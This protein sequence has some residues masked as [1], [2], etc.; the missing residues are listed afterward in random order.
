[1]LFSIFLQY[2]ILSIS[3]GNCQRDCNKVKLMPKI[4][5]NIL[6][7]SLDSPMYREFLLIRHNLLSKNMADQLDIYWYVP[8]LYI[9]LVLGNCGR[10]KGLADKAVVD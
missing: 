8:Y 7:M 2:N 5:V 1:M 6:P 10:L 3:R 4:E 9:I